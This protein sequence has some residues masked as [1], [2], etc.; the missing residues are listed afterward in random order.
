MLK[1][2]SLLAALLLVASLSQAMACE[3]DKPTLPEIT[4]VP[5]GTR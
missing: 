2:I 3:K 5:A 4:P 1:N